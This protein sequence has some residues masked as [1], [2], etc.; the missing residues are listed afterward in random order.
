MRSM[1]VE[2]SLV[3]SIRMQG[4]FVVPLAII[5]LSPRS[6][7]RFFASVPGNN[8]A[9]EADVILRHP[10]DR[11]TLLETAAY[12]AAVERNHVG[13][14]VH[15]L[16]DIVHDPAGYAVVHDFRHRPPAKGEHRRA[17]SHRF[18]H[19]QSERLG[20]VDRAEKCQRLAEEGGFFAIVDFTDVSTPGPSSSGSITSRKYSA[21]TLSTLA[22]M[23]S[24]MPSL[25][26]IS[27]AQSGRFSLE[28]R[29]KNAI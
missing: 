27:M 15:G 12:G 10:R 20:P 1:S 22:A 18:D 11:E 28:M 14:R 13:E 3:L 6:V 23:R 25:R 19:H 8:L 4:R 21:S 17:A 2:V 9:V 7:H 5:G 16:L 24:G 29:P 26:A